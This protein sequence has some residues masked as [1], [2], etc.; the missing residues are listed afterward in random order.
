MPQPG[1]HHRCY[2]SASKVLA[3]SVERS[4]HDGYGFGTVGAVKFTGAE[5]RKSKPGS[6]LRGD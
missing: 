1:A 2:S 4:G 3:D 6:G 5:G